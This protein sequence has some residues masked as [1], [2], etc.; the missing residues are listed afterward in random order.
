MIHNPRK[1]RIR[2]RNLP[3]RSPPHHF[4]RSHLA[5]GPEE[6]SRLTAKIS[7]AP[8]IDDNPGNIPPRI[9]PAARKHQRHLF[10][11][12]PFILRVRRAQQAHPSP[13]ALLWQRNPWLRKRD[14]QT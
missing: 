5:L 7:M 13:R 9:K 12:Q 3:E 4:T 6:E 8:A 2:K 1:I 10:A 14:F 11:D